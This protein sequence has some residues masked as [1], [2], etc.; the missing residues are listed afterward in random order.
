MSTMATVKA[1][2][3]WVSIYRVWSQLWLDLEFEVSVGD[4]FFV[5]VADR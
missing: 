3:T 2:A 4:F 1:I 5:A